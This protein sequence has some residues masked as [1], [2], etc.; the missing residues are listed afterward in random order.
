MTD[1]RPLLVIGHI[2][3]PSL[4]VIARAADAGATTLRVARPV[5]GE[6][7]PPL[8]EVRG[9]I[10]L[11]GPQSAYDEDRYPYLASEKAYL[12]AS[13]A[14]DVPTLAICL[15]SHLAAEALGGEAYAGVAGLEVGLVD[16]RA[17]DD[18]GEALEGR[19]FSF[20]SDTLR[21]PLGARVLAVSDRYV[22]AWSSGSVLAI[23][24]HP[25]LD[26]TGIATLLALEGEKLAASGVDVGALRQELEAT[27]LSS[28]ERLVN[29][30]VRSLQGTRCPAD[31]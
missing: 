12:A 9:V 4:E 19:F 22:Q 2:G 20:H 30:W 31:R 26:H 21:V 11:G 1:T 5:R 25:D 28:G 10:V 17:V 8:D 7:L 3:Q 18:A 24:F 23:Q 6:A 29:D 13:H 27:D 14:A 15:G 16:V